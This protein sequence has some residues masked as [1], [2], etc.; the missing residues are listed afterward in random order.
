MHFYDYV[1]E[2]SEE[3]WISVNGSGIPVALRR[4]QGKRWAILLGTSGNSFIE[5]DSTTL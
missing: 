3:L 5:V 1:L 4:W 2:K